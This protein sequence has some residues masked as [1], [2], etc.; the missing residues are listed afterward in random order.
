MTRRRLVIGIMALTLTVP[1]FIVGSGVLAGTHS[2]MDCED[3][4]FQVGTGLL[5][6]WPNTDFCNFRYPS[7]SGFA[8]GGVA[9]DGIPPLYPEGYVYPED[10]PRRGGEEA[11]NTVSYESVDS[12]NGWLVD[13]HPVIAVEINGDVR[14]FPLG[15]LTRH[16]IANTEIGGVPVAVT[17]CPL[18]N[19]GVV[20]D[21]RLNDETL[22]FGVSGFLRFSDLIMWDHQTESWWQQSTG[23]GLVG[24]Y[25]DE[26]LIFI[27]SAMTSYGQFKMQ[28]PDGQV[29]SSQG[30]S[31]DYNPYIGYDS[32][33]DPFLYNGF[34]DERLEATARVLGYRHYDDNGEEIFTAYP[35]ET[36]EETIVANDI[37]GGEPRVAF[38]QPG[39]R[40]ALD[41]GNINEARAVGAANLFDPTLEDGT[42]L[43]F[44][45]DGTTI[46]DE[47]T[48]STWNIFGVATDGEL[49][50]TQLTQVISITHFWFA[51]QAF[52]TTVIW[53][54]GTTTDQLL[55]ASE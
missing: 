26:Q 8:S 2:Q 37:V 32:T 27:P 34:I 15:I 52:H 21:R 31:A 20:F 5:T 50:G 48:S 22:V 14:A 40:S 53:E 42:I 19:T 45:A 49:A 7:S 39:A 54:P 51:W 30:D 4:D 29:L 44:V 18:C 11:R 10:I 28:F 38:W 47:Q 41:S 17:F 24:T 46:T 1:A 35:F 43:T 55:A 25:A 13:D 12:A 36:L 16:E 9:R 3:D 6:A 23:E 33:D